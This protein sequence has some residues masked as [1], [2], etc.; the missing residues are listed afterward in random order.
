MKKSRSG[1]GSQSKIIPIALGT[2]IIWGFF[3]AL[4]LVFTVILFSGDD[5]TASTALFSLISFVASGALATLINKRIFKSSAVN[6]PLFSALSS[7]IIYL[8]ACTVASGRISVGCIINTACFILI[9]MLA[10][11]QRKKKSKRRAR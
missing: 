4:S 10:S 6:A 7:A 11:I 5:P 9:C 3:F 8:V 1:K 2:L